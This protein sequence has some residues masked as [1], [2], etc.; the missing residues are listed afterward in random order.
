[1]KI[2]IDARLTYYRTGGISTY[3]RNLIRELETLDQQND[4]VVFH[5]RKA[6]QTIPSRFARADLWTPCHHRLERTAL[7][8]E[9]AR[10]GLDVLHSPD[11]I[12]PRRGAKRHI[13]SVHDLSFLHYPDFMTA[14]SRRYYNDQIKTAVA[15]ADHILTISKS[16]Q[17]DVVRLLGVPSSKMTVHYPGVNDDF[18][19]QSAETV[20]AM[21]AQLE[22]PKRRTIFS[23][24]ARSSRARTFSV[25]S[26]PTSS[27]AP[28]FHKRRPSSSRAIPVGCSTNNARPSSANTGRRRA[29]AGEHPAIAAPRA[30]HRR[31]CPHAPII[32]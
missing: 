6:Q 29:L 27:F 19:P 30:L 28:H 4:Y 1:M 25:C 16:T 14:E 18:R 11:F 7:S 12:P 21:R 24:S 5:S 23:S 20:Q 10:F 22:L 9:L 3:T 15:H 31:D 17:R 2:G 13:I 8:V 32:L 26:T